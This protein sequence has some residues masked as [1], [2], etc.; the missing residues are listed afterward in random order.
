MITSRRLLFFV[1]GN[2]GTAIGFA[3]LFVW[4]YQTRTKLATQIDHIVVP[5][6]WLVGFFAVSF[7]SIR[8]GTSIFKAFAISIASCIFFSF[9]LLMIVSFVFMPRL[10]PYW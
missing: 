5:Y 4:L 8:N 6:V 9:L 2:A 7:I 3:I 10:D 1:L